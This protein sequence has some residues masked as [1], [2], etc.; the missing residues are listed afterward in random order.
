MGAKITNNSWTILEIRL[1]IPNI[2]KKD[3]LIKNIHKAREEQEQS[4]KCRQL[5][6]SETVKDDV[7]DLIF[8]HPARGNQLNRFFR[9]RYHARTSLGLWN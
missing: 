8:I 3:A 2:S 7:K 1:W 6:L 4:N 9:I 5:S